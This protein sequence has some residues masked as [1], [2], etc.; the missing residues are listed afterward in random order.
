MTTAYDFWVVDLDGTLV[1]VTPDYRR[2]VM[3]AVGDHINYSFSN[4]QIERLW[5]GLGARPSTHLQRWGIDPEEFWSAF[6]EVEDPVER[7]AATQLYPDAAVIGAVTQPVGLVTHCQSYLT[8]RVLAELGI[9]E[10]FDTVV[11]CDDEIGWKPDPQPVER[12]LDGLP[13]ETSPS[14]GALI[15]DSSVDVG[16]AWNT[17]LDAIHVERHGHN[18]RGCCIRADQNVTAL[19]EC[20]DE[21]A[22]QRVSS[23]SVSP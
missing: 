17:G 19:T 6:H 2:S 14:S 9:E 10:W 22:T 1:D 4:Q 11:C 7:A 16:A 13:V 18:R 20:I 15:G 5:H 23:D 8:D 3:A 21:P 12:A